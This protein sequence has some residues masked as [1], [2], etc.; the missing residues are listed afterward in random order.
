MYDVKACLP[1]ALVAAAGGAG[2]LQAY[3]LLGPHDSAAAQSPPLGGKR[4]DAGLQASCRAAGVSWHPPHL[5]L[6]Q[7]A[8]AAR[9]RLRNQHTLVTVPLPL[10]RAS[11][12][13]LAL[14][15]SMTSP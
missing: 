11:R 2:N 10:F 6:L 1:H 7:S 4:G 12:C 14:S 15:T 9:K 3:N 8:S 5:R 13:C